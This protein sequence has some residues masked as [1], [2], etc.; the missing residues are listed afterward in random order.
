MSGKNA[1]DAV[2]QALL[3]ALIVTAVD[4][5]FVQWTSYAIA[6]SLLLSGWVANGLTLMAVVTPVALC[7]ALV[8]GRVT[9]FTT[10]RD[11]ARHLALTT[12]SLFALA[13]YNLVRLKAWVPPVLGRATFAVAVVVG[14]AAAILLAPKLAR[15]V[16]VAIVPIGLWVAMSGSVLAWLVASQGRSQGRATLNLM[17][18][19]GLAIGFPPRVAALLC[20]GI[21]LN[22][23]ALGWLLRSPELR[24]GK[25]L[26]AVA[27]TLAIN[28]TLSL[29]T[30]GIAPGTVSPAFELA[31]L[32]SASK[33][34]GTNVILIVLDTVGARHL[35][36][37][38]YDRPTTPR[39][40]ALAAK[41]TLYEHAYANGGCHRLR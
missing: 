5:H 37:Y 28:S 9:G 21:L 10:A 32:R 19:Q 7:G 26:A 22:A 31:D 2:V 39:L 15:R 29:A 36:A 13:F 20:V 6:P 3:A 17:A 38:G 18:D 8:A 27:S 41:S 1:L 4:V 40:A 30:F 23:G 11:N 33:T 16:K 24:T 25:V 14:A 35:P 34:T 12:S